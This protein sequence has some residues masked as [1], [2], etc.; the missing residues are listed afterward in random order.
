MTTKHFIIATAGHVDH[1]KSA[2]VKALTGTDPDRLPEEKARQITID[3]GFAELN[4]TAA[5]GDKI[6]AGIVDVP[7]HEDFVRNMI[8]GVGSIDLAL[9]VVAADDGWMPQTEEHLQILIYL[10]VQRAVIALTKTDLGSVDSV[11]EEIRS[12]LRETV[13][14][15]SPI[16]STSVRTGEGIENLKMA[17]ASE[18]ANMQPQRDFG[19]PRLFIDRAFTLRGIGSVVTGTLTGGCFDRGQSIIV[20]PQNL[21]ARIRSIQSHGVEIDFAQPGMRTALNLP[22]VAIDQIKRGEVIT[23]SDLGGASLTLTA[24]VVKSPRL[25]AKE[26]AARPLK[27][28]SSVYLHHGTSRMAARVT[29]LERNALEPGQKTI[30]HLKLASPMFAFVGDRFVIRDASEQYTIAGGMVLDPDGANFRGGAAQLN[31]LAMRAMAPDDVDVCVR[32]EIALR[33]FVPRKTLLTKS[34]FSGGEISEALMRLQRDDEIALCDEIAADREFWRKLRNQAVA[35]IEEAHRRNPERAGLDVHEL[36]STLRIQEPDV[37]EALTSDLCAGAFVRKGSAIACTSHRPAL[38]AELQ[39][40]ERKIREALSE[41]PFDPPSRREIESDSHARQVVRF[42]I[43][44]RDAIEI[45]PDVMLLRKN[46]E[47]MKA[48]IADFISKSGPAT[49]SELR[50]EVGSSRRIMVPLL[51]KL[52]RQGFTRRIGDKRT[53]AASRYM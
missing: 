17:L 46:F 8:A 1:G 49:V 42:L 44:S 45:S 30:A 39:P 40:L 20:R 51:E 29:L 50:Q 33:G 25:R 23:D 41:K 6:H 10:G 35:L 9:L 21:Q 13:F 48:R 36:R 12:Q 52:D 18:L 22:D 31:L 5:N 34:H 7:G 14:A 19:K 53:L 32:S 11:T 27:T 37:F 4:L 28:G 3:L 24:H 15:R 47:G 38:P 43:E 26:P 2:L 16:V